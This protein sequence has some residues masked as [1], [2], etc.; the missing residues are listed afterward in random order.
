MTKLKSW[1]LA[2]SVPRITVGRPRVTSTFAPTPQLLKTSIFP[3]CS[4]TPLVLDLANEDEV[5]E[6][7]EQVVHALGR[8]SHSPAVRKLS[9]G[10]LSASKALPVGFWRR[11]STGLRAIS[12]GGSRRRTLPDAA[13]SGPDLLQPGDP[14]DDL[15]RADL[16]RGDFAAFSR[17]VASIA[18]EFDHRAGFGDAQTVLAARARSFALTRVPRI[19]GNAPCLAFSSAVEISLLAGSS[20]SGG[21][22]GGVNGDACGAGNGSSTAPSDGDGGSGSEA[23]GGAGGF[24]S[25]G[26]GSSRPKRLSGVTPARQLTLLRLFSIF[27][28]PSVELSQ[29][30]PCNRQMSRLL[31][32]SVTKTKPVPMAGISIE[33]GLDTG[34]KG[35]RLVEKAKPPK[36][37]IVR[38]GTEHPSKLPPFQPLA[39]TDVLFKVFANTA[40]TEEG[41][42]DFVQRF[43]PLTKGGWGSEGE[44]ANLVVF[45][46]EYMRGVLTTWFGKQRPSVIPTRCSPKSL[47]QAAGGQSV[48]HRSEH[49][50]GC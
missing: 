15:Q 7:V 12:F 5:R 13:S 19:F 2:W 16:E 20:G 45:Q 32:A 10:A 14:R 46:A 33:S 31:Y 38:N 43:G 42:L 47:P 50:V 29:I 44:D 21:I 34:P 28:L 36:L 9:R 35:Y 37:R 27:D 1:S 17:F 39:S 25:G 4:R 23:A 6:G 11:R 24:G 40:T 48:R 30:D 41:A 3:N 26:S 22:G 18:A 8:S 49:S